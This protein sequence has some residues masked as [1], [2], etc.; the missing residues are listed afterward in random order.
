MKAIPILFIAA[1][2]SVASAQAASLVDAT[3]PERIVQLM[4]GF[5]SST[6]ESDDYGDPLITGRVEGSKYGIYFYGCKENRNCK[7]IQFSAAWA[8]YDISLHRI[9]E[10]N[11]TKRY[12]K[13]YL[14]NDGDPAIEL[15]VNLTYGVSRDNFDDTIDW[16]VITMKEFEKYIQSA[17]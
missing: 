17:N 14:D 9:N 12:G 11:K 6:L 3:D 15:S 7:D 8:G 16:W 5:G 10:W 1:G 2:L 4:R 13:A